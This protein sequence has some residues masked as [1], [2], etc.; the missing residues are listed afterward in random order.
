ME[1]TGRSHMRPARE[2]QAFERHMAFLRSGCRACDWKEQ[3]D[4]KI[5][6]RA[7]EES[8]GDTQTRATNEIANEGTDEGQM[9]AVK[10]SHG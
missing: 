2:G 10:K 8:S 3:R 9:R 1:E 5:E 7:A 6:T 4:T